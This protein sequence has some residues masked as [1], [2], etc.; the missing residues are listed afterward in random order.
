MP[1]PSRVTGKQEA[2]KSS[3]YPD[4]S[5]IFRMGFSKT[6]STP[7]K[8]WPADSAAISLVRNRLPDTCG[9]VR[10]ADCTLS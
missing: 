6:P 7:D 2:T 5:A 3:C 9:V 4:L 10:V 1:F 8:K